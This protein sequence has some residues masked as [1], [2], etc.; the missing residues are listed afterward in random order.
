MQIGLCNCCPNTLE[1][2]RLLVILV[3]NA[4]LLHYVPKQQ[5]VFGCLAKIMDC[6]G[7]REA[8]NLEI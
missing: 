1:V 2:F 8:T 6:T 5:D 7:L 3:F 4:I